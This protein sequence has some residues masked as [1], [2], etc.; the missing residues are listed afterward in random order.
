MSYLDNLQS[1]VDEIKKLK[2]KIQI[3]EKQKNEVMKN[4]F[5]KNKSKV[6]KYT[7]FKNNSE[8]LITKN[9]IAGDDELDISEYE[10]SSED[11]SS[12]N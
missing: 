8:M 5:K 6:L 10:I 3:L 7:P 9:D 12:E 11:T 4:I 2:D 1:I